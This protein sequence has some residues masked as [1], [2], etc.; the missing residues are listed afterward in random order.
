MKTIEVRLLVT[1]GAAEH[2][3]ELLDRVAA[4]TGVINA[5]QLDTNLAFP[6]GDVALPTAGDWDGR[7]IEG[8]K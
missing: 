2:I 4:T 8:E 6:V 1:D 3:P 5:I 7:P